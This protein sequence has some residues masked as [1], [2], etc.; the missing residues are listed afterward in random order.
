M[1]LEEL[2]YFFYLQGSY[3]VRHPIEGIS[4]CFPCGMFSTFEPATQHFNLAS[5]NVPSVINL[6][7]VQL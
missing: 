1:T 4:D 3:M 6:Y 2:Q 7:Y 5:I